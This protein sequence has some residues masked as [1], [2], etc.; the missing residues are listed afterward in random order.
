MRLRS[1]IGSARRSPDAPTD[2]A[3]SSDDEVEETYLSDELDTDEDDDDNAFLDTTS[4]VDP[5]ENGNGLA[6]IPHSEEDSALESQNS[7]GEDLNDNDGN[8]N[9]FTRLT[10]SRQKRQ[11]IVEE[12]EQ[13]SKKIQRTVME[14]LASEEDKH[15]KAAQRK[16]SK[17]QKMEQARKT[18]L[19]KLLTKKQRPLEPSFME[20]GSKAKNSTAATSGPVPKGVTRFY[21]NHKETFVIYPS[22]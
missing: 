4:E 16:I 5:L 10:T 11:L 14:D 20:R 2:P 22:L 12:P 9:K 1:S 19:S 15:K 3:I 17:E 7:E 18:A 8:V 13:I 21:D 6:N